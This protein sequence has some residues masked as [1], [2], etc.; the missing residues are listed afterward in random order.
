MFFRFFR[1]GWQY[2]HID[3]YAKGR[4]TK[5]PTT[6][7]TISSRVNYLYRSPCGRSLLTLDE[8]ENYLLQTNSKLTIK[9]FIDDRSTHLQS[10]ITYDS[11]YI[12]NEDITQGKEYVQIP[13]YNE[14]NTNL[15]ES[16]LYGTETR[17]KLIF[18]NE[19]TTMTCCSC[20]DK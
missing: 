10:S 19:T 5:K 12:L 17:S 6:H 15:P 3:R 7:K 16:F 9:L 14:I 8:I 11:Q 1:C 4:F 18:R 20:P 13:V 2:F